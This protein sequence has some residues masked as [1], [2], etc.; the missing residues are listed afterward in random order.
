MSPN[1]FIG[2]PVAPGEWFSRVSDP[3]PGVRLFHPDDLHL[4]LAF[5][6]GVSEEAALRAWDA[7]VWNLSSRQVTLGPVVAMGSPRSPSAFSALLE[8]GRAEVEAEMG[9]ARV[10]CFTAA[11]SLPEK[12]PPKAHVTVAR[13]GRNATPEV[14]EAGR[15]WGAALSLGAPEVLLDR[16]A[17]YTW[18]ADRQRGPL[19]RIVRARPMPAPLVGRAED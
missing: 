16:L 5:L 9:A 1:W 2:V 3:P 19:F 13:P 11:G 7:L 17:L 10:A 6:G 15:L 4:T 8:E 18:A 14:R 12:W